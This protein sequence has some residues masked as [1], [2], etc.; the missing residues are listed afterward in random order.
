M[1][2]FRV[3]KFHNLL[4]ARA[5][6]SLCGPHHSPGLDDNRRWQHFPYAVRRTL[7]VDH[8]LSRRRRPPAWVSEK[9]SLVARPRVTR[10]HPTDPERPVP[11]RCARRNS[12]RQH[13]NENCKNI[14]NVT[15]GERFETTFVVLR[16][17]FLKNPNIPQNIL[18]PRA[19]SQ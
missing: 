9:R 14:T 13:Y 18:E 19:S 5:P 11:G 8:S 3:T 15:N 6:W 17:D 10:L 7:S 4:W 12:L 2:K 16:R 1:L